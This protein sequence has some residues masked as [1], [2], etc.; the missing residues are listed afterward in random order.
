MTDLNQ[1]I[2]PSQSPAPQQVAQQGAE[3]SDSAGDEETGSGKKKLSWRAF[4]PWLPADD[5]DGP[6]GRDRNGRRRRRGDGP[7]WEYRPV[8]TDAEEDVDVDEA[9]AAE[10]A[11][12]LDRQRRRA[13]ALNL[14][15][16][17]GRKL[18]MRKRAATTAQICAA[19]PLGVHSAAMERGMFL[20]HD[21][22]GGGGAFIY[23]PFEALDAL[24]QYGV[25]NTNMMLFGQPGYGKSALIK[26][27][28]ERM[29]AVYGNERLTVVCDVKGEY[30]VLAERM[31]MTRITLHPG[32]DTVVNPLEFV[33]R[34][35][36][37]D[38]VTASRI[39]SLQALISMVMPNRSKLTMIEKRMLAMICER[40]ASNPHRQPVL[41]DVIDGLDAPTQE[42]CDQ[43]K[44]GMW[45]LQQALTDV[46]LALVELC[47]AQFGG[48][49]NGQSTVTLDPEST[50][51]VIDI[52]EASIDD[53]ALALVWV[54]ASTWL[55]ML[56][57]RVDGRRKVQVF[58]ESWKMVRHEPLALFLQ[59]CWKLGRTKG[60]ANIAIMH[61][62]T[63]LSSQARDGSVTA[64]VA[65]GLI[66]D[67]A[68]RVTYH[69]NRTD[70]AYSSDVMGYGEGERAKIATLGQGQSFWM[71]GELP[72]QLD[73]KLYG[74][75]DAELC[76]TNAV[77]RE[78]TDW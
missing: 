78:G 55:R 6:K 24:K 51:I 12:R 56:M 38:E 76:D 11:Q 15:S 29:A 48:M 13:A 25:T 4:V 2:R 74:Q 45:E 77:I 42:M 32:G 36:S 59:D 52:S 16:A 65:Q 9:T 58:D 62:L 35:E 54:A 30:A 71:L 18:A 7:A 23:D 63:D 75:A 69:Q 10:T 28:L 31:G 49:F 17:R 66:S 72:V 41:T 27:M 60:G 43:A 20:G 22:L 37:F 70:L 53:D 39:S 46:R 19:Y 33:G 61:R 47:G 8:G 3:L 14:G 26:T 50:G 34:A 67:T 1:L 68:V 44:L 73:H 21:A 64:K 40:F 57:L 5:A